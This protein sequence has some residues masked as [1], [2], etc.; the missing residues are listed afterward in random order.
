MGA[1]DGHGSRHPSV[2]F[3]MGADCAPRF[4][5]NWRFRPTKEVEIRMRAAR[6]RINLGRGPVDL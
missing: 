2:E 1:I 6:Q 4:D 5:R 3:E